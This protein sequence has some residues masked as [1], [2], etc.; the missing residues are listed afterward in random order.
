MRASWREV[1][2]ALHTPPPA[3]APVKRE[4]VG[5]AVPLELQ[6]L[7]RAARPTTRFWRPSPSRTASSWSKA[8][9]RWARHPCW[10]AGFSRPERPGRASC[11]RTSRPWARRHLASL[12][13]LLLAL[14]ESIADQLD[15]DADPREGWNAARAPNTNMERFLRREVLGRGPGAAGVGAGR[16]GPAVPAAC[17]FGSEVFGLF[18]SWHNRRA[19]DPSGPW[20]RL[21]LAIAYATEAHL[22]ITDLNQSPFNVGTRLTLEDFT[23]GAGGGPERPPRAAAAGRRGGG[24]VL[25]DW[26]AGSR[27][28]CGAAWT[29][30]AGAG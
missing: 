21:T 5:G 15:L 14:A 27:I 9:G 29:R 25:L 10:R 3:P 26:S 4:P 6:V 17:D 19:L 7:R 28:W 23:A 13:A 2:Q 1:A 12:D 30:S 18:R 20:S 8:R 11:S 24:A 16:G 22:F